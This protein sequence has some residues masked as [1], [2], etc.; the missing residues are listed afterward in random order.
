MNEKTG[1]TYSIHLPLRIRANLSILHILFN[2][3]K[4]IENLLDIPPE[5]A[6]EQGHGDGLEHAEDVVLQQEA[7]VLV[8]GAFDP[9]AQ[10][11]GLAALGDVDEAKLGQHGRVA[12]RHAPVPPRQARCL[13]QLR[14]PLLQRAAFGRRRR[15][16]LERHD[17]VPQ[18]EVSPR[19]QRF[20]RLGEDGP[21]VLEACHHCAHWF[22]FGLLFS[23]MGWERAGGEGEEWRW[24]MFL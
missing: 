8:V 18:L 4:E 12:R 10:G 17:R 15:E 1:T 5:D 3:F 13:H 11:D 7:E 19:R 20:V 14:T 21:G 9:G 6:G 16:E 24:S 22:F 2:Q 23:V